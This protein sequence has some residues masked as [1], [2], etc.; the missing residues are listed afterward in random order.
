MPITISHQPAGVV[1]T[2]ETNCDSDAGRSTSN[3]DS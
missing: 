2:S 1:S 3:S